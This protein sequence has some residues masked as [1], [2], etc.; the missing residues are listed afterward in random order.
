[1]RQDVRGKR[2]LKLRARFSYRAPH[3]RRIPLEICHSRCGRLCRSELHWK[4]LDSRRSSIH[5]ATPVSRVRRNWEDN[6]RRHSRISTAAR[7]SNCLSSDS[8]ESQNAVSDQAES[9][10][11]RIRYGGEDRWTT[12]AQFASLVTQILSLACAP[13]EAEDCY[14]TLIEVRELL[15]E[16]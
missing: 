13:K 16:K 10:Y 2:S 8:F 5:Q 7:R 3:V 15:S 1:M 11:F 12:P 14:Q 9:R 6:Q 4:E